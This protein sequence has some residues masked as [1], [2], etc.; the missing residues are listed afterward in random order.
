MTH[1]FITRLL[2]EKPDA[3]APDGSEVR[4]LAATLRGSMAQF[5]LPAGKVSIAVCHRTVD[6]LWYFTSGSGKLWRKI[7]RAEET[8]DVHSGISISIPVGTQ[9]QFRCDSPGPLQAV[10]V[11][12]PP[13]PG[14]D[15]AFAVAGIWMPVA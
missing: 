5:S 14:S 13:W 12:M 15:E 2:A 7:N 9:F 1:D 3:T 11:T 6:E 8:I 10:G 4:I